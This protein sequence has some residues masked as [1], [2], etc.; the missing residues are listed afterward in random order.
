M[1]CLIAQSARL[2]TRSGTTERDHG[3]DCIDPRPPVRPGIWHTRAMT[4]DSSDVHRRVFVV[5]GRDIDARQAM[6]DYLRAVGLEPLEWNQAIRLTSKPA[7]Y[8]GE[9]LEAAFAYAQAVV[10]LFTP[11]DEAK[12]RSHFIT[13]SDPV[14]ETDATPQPRQNVLFEAG[15]AMGR[16]ED[17]TILV[18]LGETRPFSDIAGRHVVRMNDSTVKRQELAQRLELAGCRVDLTGVDWHTAGTFVVVDE[19]Q[20]TSTI[21]DGLD[22]VLAPVVPLVAVEPPGDD[23]EL[24]FLE[25]LAEAEDAFPAFNATMEDL[26]ADIQEIGDTAR[27]G[28]A[29]MKASDARGGGSRGRLAV[30]IRFAHALEPITARTEQLVDEQRVRARSMDSGLE[31]M[32]GRIRTGELSSEERE[33]AN[34]MLRAMIEAGEAA[35]SGIDSIRSFIDSFTTVGQSARPVR[36]VV[37][38]LVTAYEGLIT[39]IERWVEWGNTAQLLLADL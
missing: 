32:F 29:E 10:V 2:A 18:Q 6:F 9:I 36:R 14:Y 15:M 1:F 17:R 8:V 26:T 28:S 16:S 33:A 5:H 39:T 24:G 25:R 37:S 30:A 12:L 7:P 27:N 38:R 19:P 20:E 4:S 22:E 13:P 35:Q 23:E 3:S 31:W 21:T 11:D 34:G